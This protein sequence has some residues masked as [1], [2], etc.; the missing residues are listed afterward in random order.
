MGFD[1]ITLDGQRAPLSR[2]GAT[3][4]P[5]VGSY[6]V[7]VAS[8]EEVGVPAMTDGTAEVL[9]VDEIGLMELKSGAFRTAIA[10]LLDDPR[11]LLA[12][13]RWRR[14]PFCDSVKARPDVELIEVT[15][16]NRDALADNLIARILEALEGV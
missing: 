9:V 3:S 16:T 10:E 11:P 5:R 1:I 12:T 2:K 6:R 15:P 7:D 4:G 14:E 8:L 13:I